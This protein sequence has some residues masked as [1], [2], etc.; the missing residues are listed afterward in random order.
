MHLKSSEEVTRC[1]N[2]MSEAGEQNCAECGQVC[3]RIII[4]ADVASQPRKLLLCSRH[5]M[6]AL[7]KYS[8]LENTSNNMGTLNRV[9][10][11]SA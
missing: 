3:Y 2:R 8:H 5:F 6:E 10:F 7:H 4:I 1:S 9:A 11:A